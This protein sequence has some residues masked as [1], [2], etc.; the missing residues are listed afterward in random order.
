MADQTKEND[1]VIHGSVPADEWAKF[2]KTHFVAGKKA[3]EARSAGDICGSI[4]C[5]S[6][7]PIS[8]SKLNGC[9]VKTESDGSTTIYCHYEAVAR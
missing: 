9:T 4:G 6:K 7:H 3:A 1:H 8:G 2:I 5:P